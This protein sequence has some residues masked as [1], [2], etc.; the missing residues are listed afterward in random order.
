M[1]QRLLHPW[2]EHLIAPALA[3]LRGALGDDR[4]AR[5]DGRALLLVVGQEVQSLLKISKEGKLRAVGHPNTEIE[6]HRSYMTVSLR[7]FVCLVAPP[8]EPFRQT[9]AAQPRDEARER[10]SPIDTDL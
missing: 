1:P 8:S 4:L 5:K 2:V 10:S 9:R 7:L 3:H 6:R